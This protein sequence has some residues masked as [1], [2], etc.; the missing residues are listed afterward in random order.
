MASCLSVQRGVILSLLSLSP[1]GVIVYLHSLRKKIPSTAFFAKSRQVRMR[2]IIVPCIQG[3][4]YGEPESDIAHI[5]SVLLLASFCWL[6]EFC[7]QR[8]ARC[9]VPGSAR[10]PHVHLVRSGPCAL[11]VNKLTATPTADL[12]ASAFVG[13][14]NAASGKESSIQSPHAFALWC[15]QSSSRIVS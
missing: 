6:F 13:P 7:F 9:F 1:A 4:P 2:M 10:A 3:N 14:G 8:L 11:A 5:A 12:E 15:R